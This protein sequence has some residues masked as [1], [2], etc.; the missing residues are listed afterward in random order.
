MLAGMHLKF[1]LD[2]IASHI[3]TLCQRGRVGQGSYDRFEVAAS[4]KFDLLFRCLRLTAKRTYIFCAK[5]YQHSTPTLM[6]V[7]FC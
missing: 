1:R 3:L 6:V 2:A 4:R 5:R 7:F